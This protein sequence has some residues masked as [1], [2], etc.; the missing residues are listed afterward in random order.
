LDILK[1]EIRRQINIRDH[2]LAEQADLV[3][4]YRP[5]SEPDS[6][7]PTGGVE[8]EIHTAFVK[9]TFSRTRVKPS[10]IIYHP[11]SDEKR[12]RCL[13]FEKNWELEVIPLCDPTDMD[14]TKRGCAELMTDPKT[15]LDD[16]TLAER[17]KTIFRTTKCSVRFNPSE[18]A[19]GGETLV[20]TEKALDHLVN[21]LIN[22]TNIMHSELEHSAP[23][24]LI[25]F[26]RDEITDY[27]DLGKMLEAI[28][29]GNFVPP[30]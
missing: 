21:K 2:I 5:F 30:S 3:F 18:S 14:A 29:N 9:N 12:R 24:D 27:Y 8:E 23:R 22:D 19:M 7:K 1:Y 6:T 4:A 26:I 16:E 17:I 25:L 15:L 28:L 11:Y 13:E 20:A 10:V